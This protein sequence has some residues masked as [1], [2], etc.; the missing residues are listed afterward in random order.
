MLRRSSPNRIDRR[1]LAKSAAVGAA[2]LGLGSRALMSPGTAGAQDV[3]E[4]NF[5]NPANTPVTSP[6]MQKLVDQFNATIGKD[7]GI[8]VNNIFKDNDPNYV[9]YTTAMTS[10]G[11]PDVVLTFSFDPVVSWAANGFLQPLDDYV[12]ALGIKEENYFS[13]VW[14][15]SSF[16]GHTWG[17][18]QAFDFNQLCYNTDIYDGEPP[19]TFDELDALAEEFTLYDSSGNLTQLGVIP[20][21]TKMSW[22]AVWGTTFYDIA[23][24]KW[25]VNKPENLRHLQWCEKW[26]KKVG[27]DKVDALDSAV[28]REYGSIF[29]YG[30]TAFSLEGEY[31]P[32]NLTEQG[33]KLNYKTAHPPVGEGVP[34]GTAG[35]AGGNLFVMPA[36]SKN[37]EAAATFIT[38]MGG[39]DGVLAWCIPSGNMPPVRSAITNK[40]FVAAWPILK[41]WLESLEKDLVLP[42]TPSPVFPKFNDLYSTAVDEVTYK[43]RS[44][45]DALADVEK[46][47]QQAVEEFQQSHPNWDGE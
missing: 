11:T 2:A 19:K 29:Q 9:P 7:K 5:W 6:L 41:P 20:W 13:N 26:A 25:T 45:E 12:Q 38:Y 37:S 40:D 17:L 46:G 10:S 23:A 28:P 4:L 42:A 3:T 18:L 33:I 44:P 27:R 24:R 47:V 43:G 14:Q 32:G 22:N 15:M 34:Y 16:N 36:K 35:T 31:F 1:S 30:K 39:L 21:I 8:K